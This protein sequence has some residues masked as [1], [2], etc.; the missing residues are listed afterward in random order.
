MN[1]QYFKITHELYFVCIL[2]PHNSSL[3]FSFHTH[4]TSNFIS[5]LKYTNMYSLYTHTTHKHTYTHTT[6]GIYK[7]LRLVHFLQLLNITLIP[8]PF[9]ELWLCLCF[10]YFS[11]LQLLRVQTHTGWGRKNQVTYSTRRKT[12]AS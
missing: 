6:R 9:T 5:V 12:C 11:Y 8:C 10:S 3:I 7:V 2:F 4:T 1:L